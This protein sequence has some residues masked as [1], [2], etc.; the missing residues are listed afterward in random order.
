MSFRKQNPPPVIDA[1]YG[2]A[3]PLYGAPLVGIDHLTT[4]FALAQWTSSPHWGS[5]RH[6]WPTESDE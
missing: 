1:S 2:D 6:A 3:G 5:G 4:E